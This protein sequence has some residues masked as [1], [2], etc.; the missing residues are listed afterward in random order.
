MISLALVFASIF[1]TLSGSPDW[2][3]WSCIFMILL[4]ANIGDAKYYARVD[5]NG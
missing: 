3:Y 1:S 2:W 4:L 5:S